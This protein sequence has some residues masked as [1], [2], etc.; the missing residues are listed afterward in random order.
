MIA[1]GRPGDPADLPETMREGETP[2]SRRP[3]S[4]SICEGAFAF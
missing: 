3:V 4:E 1:L 2:S